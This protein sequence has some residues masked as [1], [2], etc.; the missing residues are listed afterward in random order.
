[1]GSIRFLANVGIQS[2]GDKPTSGKSNYIGTE[3][4]KSTRQIKKKP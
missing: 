2:K 1:M 3:L 4:I